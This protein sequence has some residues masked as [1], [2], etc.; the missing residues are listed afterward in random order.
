[1]QSDYS[2]N[3]RRFAVVG[4]GARAAMFIEPIAE[5]FSAT[6]QL[7][8]L[9]DRTTTRPQ[10][11]QKR[12]SKLYN[13]PAVPLYLDTQFDQM[14]AEQK[15]DTVIVATT[16]ATHHEYIIRALHAGCDVITEKPLTTDPKKCRAIMEA[17]ARTGRP[18][19]VTFNMRWMAPVA[20][21][22]ELIQGGSIGNVKS[23]TLEYMLDVSH[24]ADYF[25]RWHS[26]KANSGGLLV[27]KS[28]HHFD[29]VNWWLDSIPESVFAFG[30]LS[31]Y[32]KENALARGQ[33]HLTEY[34]RYADAPEDDPFRL[35]LAS[36]DR[37]RELYLEAEKEDGYIRDRNVFRE[38][39]DIEDNL[40]LL[41]RY[42]NGI[43]LT[44]SLNAFCPVEGFRA[45]INGD[46]GRIEYTEHLSTH[47]VEENGTRCWR[48][49]EVF[50]LFKN[51][52]EVDVPVEKGGHGGA[53]P[54]L[55]E[56]L[57]GGVQKSDTPGCYAGHEQGAASAVIG[58]AG[59]ISITTGQC[60]A[61]ND[62]VQLQPDRTKLS[63]LI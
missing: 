58:F 52:Y 8:A 17:A 46:A 45:S 21:V 2:R 12:I 59:N 29:M 55:Q 7:V 5:R 19:Q 33:K 41:V 35:S 44:Y 51:P 16:D 47:T 60:V 26:E 48:R 62:L 39:I 61:V 38:G 24:G 54:L 25:R 49:I 28:T 34:D 14:L 3:V 10:F 37:L 23:V 1:M 40:G 20:K 31:Y 4:A 30:K 32:G 22:R 56:H 43:L 50:P 13:Y 57:F 53:D 6:A 42:R 18:V 36:N 27:H 11:Y 63:E 9:C 15:P